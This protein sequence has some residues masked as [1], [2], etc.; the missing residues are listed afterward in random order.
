MRF[1]FRQPEDVK[2]PSLLWRTTAVFVMLSQL[3]LCDSALAQVT[4]PSI[5]AVTVSPAGN[6][7]TANMP[8]KLFI[9]SGTLFSCQSGT[10]GQVGGS[11]TASVSNSDGTL[12]ISPTSGAVVASLALGHAN[13]WTAVQQAPA[14][15]TSL[16]SVTSSVDT[17]TG[18]NYPASGQMAF[19]TGTFQ[20]FIIASGAIDFRSTVV[21]KWSSGA[22]STSVND[23]GISRVSAG[24]LQINGGTAGTGGGL[25]VPALKSTTGTRFICADTSG[26]LTSSTAACVGT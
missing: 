14:G 5:V 9:P 7:C 25:Q 19:N 26:N 8:L 24:V 4:S 15:T 2:R 17:S 23:T 13:V 6:A 16:P 12:I 11:G 1:L 22:P 18:F 21:F 10:Y 20:Q 3:L